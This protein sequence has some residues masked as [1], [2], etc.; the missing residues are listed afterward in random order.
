MG[1]PELLNTD[2]FSNAPATE[3]LD[4]QFPLRSGT[5]KE[6][7]TYLVYF[8]HLM[9]IK[10]DGSTSSLVKP[11]QFMDADGSLDGPSA[12]TLCDGDTQ[13]QI[14]LANR[15]AGAAHACIEDVRIETVLSAG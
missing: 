3:F 8:E 11:S 9:V 12:I 13:V 15:C 4:R 2:G 5:H 14:R 10:N 1:S 6:V 7:S